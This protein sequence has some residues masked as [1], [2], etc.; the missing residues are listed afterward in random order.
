MT[1]I[2]ASPF[3]FKIYTASP[4][5]AFMET[6]TYPHLPSEVSTVH[7]ALY[8]NVS[9]APELRRRLVTAAT[10]AGEDGE[11]EREAVN[12]TFVDAKLVNPRLLSFFP[13]ADS[14]ADN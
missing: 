9:N 2:F 3:T 12:Y 7:L 6:H 8:S 10:L 4:D 11:Q 14:Q 13:L 5:Y 1:R